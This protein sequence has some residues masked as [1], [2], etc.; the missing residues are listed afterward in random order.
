MGSAWQVLPKTRY[1]SRT[2]TTKPGYGT[3]EDSDEMVNYTIET[4]TKELQD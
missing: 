2:S 4:S 3:H 1:M